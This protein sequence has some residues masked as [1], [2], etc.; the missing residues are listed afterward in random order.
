MHGCPWEVDVFMKHAVLMF[1][2]PKRN[3]KV[4][5]GCSLHDAAEKAGDT[6]PIWGTLCRGDKGS[7][8]GILCR[9]DACID[10]EAAVADPERRESIW[11]AL[12]VGP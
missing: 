9:D 12:E 4:C 6:C 3:S 8:F 10:N 11:R 7:T 2:G 5:A 1:D